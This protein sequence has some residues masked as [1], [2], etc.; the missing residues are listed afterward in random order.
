[1][2]KSAILYFDFDRLDISL[3]PLSF[4]FDLPAN[5]ERVGKK[6]PFFIWLHADEDIAIGRGRGGGIAVWKKVDKSYRE[7]EE[8]TCDCDC[9]VQ[10]KNIFRELLSVIRVPPQNGDL[11]GWGG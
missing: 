2:D 6:R 1:M 5:E 7:D 10:E 8:S 4:G 3:G 11:V 9:I